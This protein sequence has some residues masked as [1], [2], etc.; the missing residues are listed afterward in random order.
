M[1]LILL[2]L[3]AL[4]GLILSASAAVG[5]STWLIPGGDEYLFAMDRFRLGI[6]G[7]GAGLSL[8]AIL[9][10]ADGWIGAR[11]R[12]STDD[13][14][15]RQLLNGI[16]FGLLPGIA[17]WKSFTQAA[18]LEA[19]TEIPP[20][21]LQ[22]PWLTEGGMYLPARIEMIL[23][24]LLFATMV[25][26]LMFRRQESVASGIL[27]GI[28][29]TL[30]SSARLITDGFHSAGR[31]FPALSGWTGWLAAGALLLVLLCRTVRAI[32]K[33]KT[34]RIWFCV[35]VMIVSVALIVLIRNHILPLE[36]P[37]AELTLT[38]CAAVLAM[39][40]VL[41]AGNVVS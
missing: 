8:L 18:G 33:N 4:L 35:P 5:V 34:G 32:R 9:A 23:A 2:I 17:L 10:F 15:G 38:V 12:H 36:N 24:L 19:G 22:I 40:A 21:I 11:L 29:V 13:N 39:K 16:G 6:G 41:H 20:G 27:A 1:S 3:Q 14:A 7:V 28:S 37:P 26:W 25:V 31:I 30:W